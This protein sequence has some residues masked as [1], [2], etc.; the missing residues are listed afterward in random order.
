MSATTKSVEFDFVQIDMEIPIAAP[1]QQVYQAFVEDIAHWWDK[2]FLMGENS[3]DIVLE[4]RPGGMLMEVDG[5]GGGCAWAQVIALYPGRSIRLGIPNGVIWAGAGFYR[6]SFE[7]AG[8]G[9]TLLKLRHE[10]TQPRSE[11]GD[12]HS[13]YVYGWN[14]LLVDR[15]KPY[16]E[17][18][19]VPDPLR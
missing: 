1:P 18:G 7:D 10:S 16:V 4:A 11:K 6:L 19:S 5:Q 12:G 15:L 3:T 2:G 13:G 9:T 8:D 17:N 14:A